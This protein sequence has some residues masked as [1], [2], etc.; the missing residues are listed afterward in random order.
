MQRTSGRWRLGKVWQGILN[1][2]GE[3]AA[4]EGRTEDGSLAG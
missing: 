3:E 2:R 4:D 1:D